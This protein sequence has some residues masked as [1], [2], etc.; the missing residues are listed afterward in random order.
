MPLP[1]R[2]A[3]RYS[4]LFILLFLILPP[5]L[6][7]GQ[8]GWMMLGSSRPSARYTR[9]SGTS[10]ISGEADVSLER[11]SIIR[12]SRPLPADAD[13]AAAITARFG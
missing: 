3:K 10:P 5:E 6:L 9:I 2:N 11:E 4:L 1:T 13:L 8:T 7:T 12:F